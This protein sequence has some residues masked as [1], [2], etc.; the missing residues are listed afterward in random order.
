M[1]REEGGGAGLG[2]RPGVECGR[3]RE[4]ERVLVSGCKELKGRSDPAANFLR[5]HSASASVSLSVKP[6]GWL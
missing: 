6:E 5:A 3:G 4:D 2:R 1:V